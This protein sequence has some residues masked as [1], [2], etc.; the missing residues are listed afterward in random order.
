MRLALILAL[1]LSAC[2]PQQDE[3]ALV[4]SGES[5]PE[6]APVPPEPVGPTPE[7][8][9]Q[10]ESRDCR[11]VAT[12]YSLALERRAFEF[13]ARFWDDPVIDGTRLEALFDGYA[14]P[15]IEIS[16]IRQEGAAGS[17]FCTV[18]GALTDAG[19]PAKPPRQGEIVLKRV[20][21][22]PGAT[23]EQLRWT[24]RSST[25]VEPMERSGKGEPA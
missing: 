24:I 9:A 12:A 20:N 19:D 17:L 23:P 22:V 21:D 13:A 15:T 11:E 18:T 6:E 10:L 14:R 4:T 2:G 16:E 7:Q 3:D 8:L 1:A 25:F 5:G